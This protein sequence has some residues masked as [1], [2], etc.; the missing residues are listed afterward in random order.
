MNFRETDVQTYIWEHRDELFSMIEKPVFETDPDKMPW[1]YEPWELLYYHALEE[2]K[3]HY[4]HLEDLNIFG[5]EVIMPKEGENPI[6]AD[7]LG[8]L[9]G[10]NGTVVCE[11][12]VN[13]HPE[14]QAYTEL[15]AYANYVRSKFAP[16]GRRDVFYLLIS[17]MEE[18]IV[19]EA[20]INSLLY[21]R[22]RV[23]AI[24]PEMGDTLESLRFKLWIP[25][26]NDFKVITRTAFAFDNI[27]VFRISW[28]GA[29][30]IWSPI[31]EGKEP[32]SEMIHRLNKVSH[33]AAQLMETSGINGFVYCLQSYPKV[34][35]NGFLENGITLCGIN[36]YKAAKTKCLLEEGCSIEE[37]IKA[38]IEYIGLEHVFP[39]MMKNCEEANREFNYWSWMAESWSSCLTRIG[40]DVVKRCNQTF[41]P[42][43]YEHGYGDFT[44]ESYLNESS[45]DKLCWNYDISLT[46]IF[47]EI[48]DLKLKKHYDAAGLYS[49]EEKG[50]IIESGMLEWHA[51][52]MMYDHNHIRDFI[53]GLIGDVSLN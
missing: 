29:T 49:K 21:D 47:R 43:H 22:N 33:Y 10:E 3:E 24:I 12:K 53:R 17:P 51:I 30:G 45:E 36:P 32:N 7:F 35:D 42:S 48:Y 5:F 28:S 23:V 15:F 40:L 2:Y 27:D 41:G 1:E 44:W 31:E 34:R 46:G 50:E 16:M 19:R 52:D 18:R 38:D 39:A 11:L 37:A 14:R 25:S 20:T 26:K 6:R 9:E 13:R 4:E 8:C